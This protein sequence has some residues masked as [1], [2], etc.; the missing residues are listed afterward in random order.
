MSLRAYADQTLPKSLF[1][2]PLLSHSFQFTLRRKYSN[3]PI[4]LFILPFFPFPFPEIQQHDGDDYNDD[5][6]E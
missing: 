4:T 6:G 5:N 1:C 2:Y 3:T